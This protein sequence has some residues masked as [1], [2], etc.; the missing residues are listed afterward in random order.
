MLL[1]PEIELKAYYSHWHK[2]KNNAT[3]S[4][5]RQSHQKDNLIAGF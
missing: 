1:I 4:Q 3:F 2:V 5:H